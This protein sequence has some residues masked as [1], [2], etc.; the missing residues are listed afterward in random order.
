MITAKTAK[1]GSGGFTLVELMIVIAIIGILAAIAVPNFMQY[2]KKL[3]LLRLQPILNTLRRAL[4]PMP[5]MRTI[6]P[7]I[8]T[9]TRH[10]TAFQTP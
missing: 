7:M 2:R 10:P 5:L 1:L 6:I 8:A 3:K 9:P 4:S